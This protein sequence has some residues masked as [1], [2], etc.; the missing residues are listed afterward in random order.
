MKSGKTEL[1]L[2]ALAACGSLTACGGSP[3]E[4]APAPA[5]ATSGSTQS[6]R[7]SANT[8]GEA[9]IAAALRA[10]GVSN[11][12]RWAKE[13]VEYRPYAVDDSDLTSLRENLAKYNPGQG[14]VD[15]IV[16]ALTP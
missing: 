16:S 10:A 15:K 6:A 12:E 9:E 1:A 11:P 4:Q 2:A 7:V 8:A 13:V 14:T 5:A 3:A